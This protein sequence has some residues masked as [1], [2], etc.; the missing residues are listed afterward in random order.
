MESSPYYSREELL[1]F[2]FESVGSHIQF[3]R[4][5]SLYRVSGFIGN[6]VRVDDF[7][8]LKG[9]LEIGSH[10]HIAAFC[11]ISG[12]RGRVVMQDFSSLG[13]RC[14]LYTGSDNYN[15]D[16]LSSSTVPEKYLDTLCGDI[17]LGRASQIGAH[18]VVLPGALVGDAASI[19]ALC[20][21]SKPVPAGAIIVSK[22]ALPIQIGSRN[23]AKIMAY[24]DEVLGASEDAAAITEGSGT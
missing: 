13:N 2:G 23:V 18:S 19:G 9:R 11:S 15:A 10:I 5:C 6:H 21:L 3:S 4:K 20:I 22:S 17:I 7:C 8:I 24:A 16:A 1:A 12:V 14:S